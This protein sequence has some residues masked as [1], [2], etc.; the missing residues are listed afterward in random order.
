MHIGAKVNPLAGACVVIHMFANSYYALFADNGALRSLSRRATHRTQ[1][2]FRPKTR[3]AYTKMFKV[4]LAFCI[5]MGVASVE[6]DVNVILSFCECLVAKN[7]S[8]S[9]VSNYLSAIKANFVLYNMCFSLLDHPRIRYFQKSIRIH[10]PLTLTPHNIIDLSMLEKVSR[11]C[12]D[13][14][15]SQV[16]RAIFLIGFFGFF[17]LSNL[18]PHSILTFDPSRHLTGHG[19][20]FTKKLVKVLIKWSKTLQDRDIVQVVSLPKIANRIIC[21]YRA[22]KALTKL[23]PMTDSESVFQI[24]MP[25]GWQPLTDTRVRKVLKSINM[26]LGLNP[27][28]FTYHCFQRSGATFAHNAHVPIQQIKHHGTWS[29]ECVWRYIQ[30]DHV[31]GEELAYSLAAAINC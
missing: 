6:I 9:M 24:K 15:F 30:S 28:F 10:R 1:E 7:C 23:Y 22:F 3:Q 4:F 2:A 16:F 5:Y 20:F 13:I 17:R 18:A 25:S 14:S 31:S 29:S 27:H 19:L 12:D 21:P 8:A 11:A 26:T